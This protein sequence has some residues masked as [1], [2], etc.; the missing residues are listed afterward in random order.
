[1]ILKLFLFWRIGLFAVTFLGAMTF[2]PSSN[3]ALGA[4]TLTKP[5]DYWLSWAQWDGGYYYQIAQRGYLYFQDYAFYPLYPVLTRAIEVVLSNTLL[6]GLLI[7]NISFLVFLKVTYNFISKK[8]AKEVAENS[9]VSILTFPTAFFA[10]AFYTE[11]LF[12]LLTILV[13]VFMYQKKLLVTGLLIS[14][15]TLTRFVGLGLVVSF[16]YYHF[17][18]T[19]QRFVPKIPILLVSVLGISIYAVYLFAHLNNPL[20]FANV[21]SIW[22]RSPN[23]P[24]STIISYFWTIF[25]NSATPLDQYFDLA[26][27]L[28]FVGILIAGIKKIPSAIWI[29]SMLVILI[30]ASS[31]TLTSMP[32]YVLSSL[33]AFIIIGEFLTRNPKLKLPI[34]AASLTLQAILAVRFIGGYWVA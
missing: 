1:M 11:G 5:F 3:G 19:R 30:P 20:A 32:R 26:I 6:S 7:S 34:W 22:Q 29:F 28:L 31:G 2:P 23:D 27:T 13:F 4:V 10:V 24:I 33:G 25:T 17:K 8:Y 21:Q 14:A 12:L 16:F 15:A 9:V 18:V